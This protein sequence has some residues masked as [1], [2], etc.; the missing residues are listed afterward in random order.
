MAVVTA[1]P[2]VTNT[3][4]AIKNAQLAQS[5]LVLLGG[6]TATV[7]RGRG[8]LQDIDQMSVMR[9]NVKW[10]AAVKVV[11]DIV[12]TLELAFQKA[13]EGIPGPVFVELPL[14]LLYPRQVVSDMYGAKG[15]ERAAGSITGKAIQT[16]LRFH[17]ARIFKGVEQ[18][19]PPSRKAIPVMSPKDA[20]VTAALELINQAQRPL[21]LIGSQATLDAAN[22]PELV[23]AVEKLGI[24]VYLSGMARGLLGKKNPQQSRHKRG[25]ALKSADLVI[26]VG[27]TCDFRLDYGGHINSRARVISINRS[28]RDLKKNR[29]PTLGAHADPAIFIRSLADK[30]TDSHPPL[31]ASWNEWQDEL[32]TTRPGPRGGYTGAS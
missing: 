30:A 14:D 20:S 6:A 25:L 12:P 32:K 5:P 22:T 13:Q 3:I 24:P 4:T 28:A 21:M 1:G 10:Q 2:G 18:V 31:S 19:P 8:A 11:R 15:G 7:L 29:R 26:L 9:A 27:V 16:Y 17:T 23:K